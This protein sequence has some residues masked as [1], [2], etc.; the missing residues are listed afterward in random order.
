[1]NRVLL[2]G[3]FLALLAARGVVAGEPARYPPVSVP[4]TA[5]RVADNVYLVQGKSGAATDHEGFISNAGFVVTDA[6][7]V[8]LDGLGSPSLAQAMR[9]LIRRV[10]DKPVVK[11][12]VTHYHADHI[13]GL[14]V[15]QDEGAQ[16]IAPAGVMAYLQGPQAAERLAERR[17]TLAPFVNE[18]TRLVFP[19][20]LV[21]EP[22]ELAVGGSTF[23]LEP[24]G[25]VHSDGDMTMLVKPAGVLFSGDLI[26]EGRVP[27]VGDADTRRWLEALD[28]LLGAQLVAL[29][30]GHGGAS[31]DPQATLVLTRDYLRFLREVMGRAVEEM[32]PFDE[33][34]AAVDWSRWEKLPAFDAANR[35]NAFAVYLRMENESMAKP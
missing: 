24:L 21:S 32:A 9:N 18:S 30:P 25:P 35:R 28:G 27:F 19:D 33:A 11:V 16:V 1:M 3:L 34:Y 12:V 2:V 14:Q 23:R 5:E 22:T 8:V 20:L 17:Q 31:R 6:G 13:Y 15:Y 29:V 7:V 26:F 4:M 10:T